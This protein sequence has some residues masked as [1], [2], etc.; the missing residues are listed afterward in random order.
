MLIAVLG[1]GILSSLFP[2]LA[3]KLL[4]SKLDAGFRR[5]QMEKRIAKLSGHDIVCRIGRVGTQLTLEV[6]LQCARSGNAIWGPMET[7][8]R[9]ANS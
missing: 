1:I 5:R 8:K 9:I 4:D 6:T 7:S 2:T 3:A